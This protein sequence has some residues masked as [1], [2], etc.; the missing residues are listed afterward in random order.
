[1]GTLLKYLFYIVLIVVIYL[2][3]KGIYDGNITESTTVGQV[4][5]DVDSG[6]KQLIKE[7]AAEAK[8]EIEKSNAG[9]KVKTEAKEAWDEATMGVQ[10]TEASIKDSAS[11]ATN[12]VAGSAKQMME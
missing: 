1:M 6:S 10:N 5:S 4:M 9:D 11:K 3:G 2:I 7:G 12:S 8:F